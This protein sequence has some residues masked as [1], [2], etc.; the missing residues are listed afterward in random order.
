M[1]C[2]LSITGELAPNG[3]FTGAAADC[4]G[5]K[6][7]WWDE[8]KSCCFVR[9]QAKQTARVADKLDLLTKVVHFDVQVRR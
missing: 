1:K 4:L 2:P 5:G 7:A 3:E 6:C 8:E 9:T